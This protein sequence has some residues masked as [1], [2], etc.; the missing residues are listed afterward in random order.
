MTREIRMSL[1]LKSQFHWLWK[2]FLLTVLFLST[3]V[4]SFWHARQH[5]QR[6]ALS[7]LL[8]VKADLVTCNSQNQFLVS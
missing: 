8:W 4:R 7:H 2:D 1:I 5:W 3:F 6:R